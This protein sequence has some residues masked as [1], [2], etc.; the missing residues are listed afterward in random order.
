MAETQTKQAE[1]AVQAAGEG[2][3]DEQPE[4]QRE[5][6]EVE[7]VI[8]ERDSYLDQLQRTLAEFANFRRR[9]EQER[10]AARQLASRDLLLQMLPVLDDFERAMASVP[11]EQRETGWVAGT[12]MIGKK[13]GGILERA[14]AKPI[15]ALGQPFDPALHEA[16]ATDPGSSGEVVV[17]VY[18]TGY[19]LGD[20]LLRPAMVKTGDRPAA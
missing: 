18:Q 11:E 20:G 17:E 4:G 12:A 15:E 16:V 7:A 8:A 14:G 5:A 13:L 19:K 3:T 2:Q 6:A 9:T 10:A 1:E